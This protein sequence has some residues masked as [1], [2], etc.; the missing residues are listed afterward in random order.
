MRYSTDV[1]NNFEIVIPSN[2]SGNGLF[3]Y[4]ARSNQDIN[5]LTAMNSFD[6]I[7]DA[8]ILILASSNPVSGSYV[9]KDENRLVEINY[10]DWRI[11]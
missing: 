11:G 4:E 6:V 10:A 3:Y 2:T 7:I 1:E 5:V 9:N 8:E